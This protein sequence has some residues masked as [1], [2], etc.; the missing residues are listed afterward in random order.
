M[1]NR[2]VTDTSM[3]GAC[4]GDSDWTNGLKTKVTE[5]FIYRSKVAD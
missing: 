2:M 3:K 5:N 4:K 1:T